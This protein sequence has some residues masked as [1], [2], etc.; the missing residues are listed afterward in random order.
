M[1]RLLLCVGALA[2][3]ATTSG[4]VT[5]PKKTVLN[6]DTTDPKWTSRKCVAARKAVYEYNDHSTTRAV[7]GIAGNLVAPFAG[8]ASSLAL[9]KSQ[10]HERRRLNRRV[11]SACISK[12]RRRGG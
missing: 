7:V 12:H 5:N 3:L 4:C 9:S 6:L 11:E 8:T 2:L 10:D 1:R